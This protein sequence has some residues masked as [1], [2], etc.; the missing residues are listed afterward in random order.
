MMTGMVSELFTTL[1]YNP[2]YNALV[3]LVTLVP[4]ADVGIA[5]VLLTLLVK[6]ALFPVAKRAQKTQEALKK[7]EPELKSLKERHKSDPQAQARAMMELYRTRKVRPF[8]SIL[9]VFIQIPVILGL[10]FVFYKGG[11]PVV[12]LEHLYS[13]VPVPENP[14][15][16]FL[17]LIDIAQTHSILFAVLAAASQ[18][19][20]V[21]FSLPKLEKREGEASLQEDFARS[22]QMNMRYVLPPIVGVVTYILP[23]AVGLYWVSNNVFTLVQ[24][25]YVRRSLRMKAVEDTPE[26]KQLSTV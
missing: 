16:L 1:V 5:V 3:F 17:G 18:Y 8:L 9:L 23:A 20:Q 26:G 10:Y 24:E 25:W 2:L 22:M 4:G 15:M 7:L 14:S 19:L 11:L 6:L 21:S 13:F 12:S